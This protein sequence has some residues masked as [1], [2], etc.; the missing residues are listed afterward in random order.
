MKRGTKNPGQKPP[1]EKITA[2]TSQ[3]QTTAAPLTPR[4]GLFA[5]LLLGFA[6]W[7]GLLLTLYFT[8][9]YPLRH[10]AKP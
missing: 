10:A 1:A 9:V 3:G 2:Q 6:V 4:P 7:L 5:I 8:T